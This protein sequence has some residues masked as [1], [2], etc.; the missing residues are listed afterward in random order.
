M[1]GYS[2]VAALYPNKEDLNYIQRTS[3]S[4]GFPPRVVATGILIKNINPVAVSLPFILSL[5]ATFTVV[6]IIFAYIRRHRVSEIGA[7]QKRF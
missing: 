5:I 6:F 7:F 2:L 3:L 1:S 4:F